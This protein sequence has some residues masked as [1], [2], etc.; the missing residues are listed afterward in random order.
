MNDEWTTWDG[1]PISRAGPYGAMVV[2]YRTVDHGIEF[3]ALHR[4]EHGPSFEGD[5]AWTPPS[6][7]RLPGEPV[8]RCAR[9]ELA[10]EAGLDLPVRRAPTSV[11][12]WAVFVAEAPAAARV[13]LDAEHDRFAWLA[14][15]D[16]LARCSPEMVAEQIRE[17]ITS[18]ATSFGPHRGHP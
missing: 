6:G 4:A 9:R 15:D 16:L 14:A 13:V 11:A 12:T 2:V 17:A 10:E 18:V 7:A 3:L 5:W 8:E 1:L